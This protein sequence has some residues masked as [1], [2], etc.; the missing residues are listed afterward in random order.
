MPNGCRPREGRHPFKRFLLQRPRSTSTRCRCF[1]TADLRLAPPVD[2][3]EVD[4]CATSPGQRGDH[5]AEGRGGAAAAA[6]HLT[7]VVGVHPDLQDRA[8]TQ[9]LVP[10][11]HVVRVLDH[12]AHQVLEGLGEHHAQASL[13]PA[14]SAVTFSA[15]SASSAAPSGV[16]E[17]GTSA[18]ASSAFFSAFFGA[19]FLVTASPLG[20]LLA[21]LSASLKIS[22]L[23]RLGSLTFRVPSVPGRPLNFCQSPVI[24][25]IAATASDGCA[26]TPSQYCARS[27][28]TSMYDGSSLGWYLPISSITLPSRF[29][30]ES[31]T[32]MRYC[33]TRIL[34]RR[35]KRILTA[36]FV[37]SPQELSWV[38]GRSVGG[39]TRAGQLDG[40]CLLG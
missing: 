12:A 28:T 35:F 10:D 18:G 6:D 21:S 11:D 9:L 3:D 14:S 22:S 2:V 23:S 38:R 8:A 40:R 36:T 19:D 37:V 33:G 26:P 25:R 27:E 30:R 20:S 4:A 34:P 16:S 24:L 7:E 39:D 29:L 17:V 32:T 15:A 5:R 1:A 13:L 31:T